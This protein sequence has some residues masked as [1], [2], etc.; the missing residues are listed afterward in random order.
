M[1]RLPTSAVALVAL[2]AALLTGLVWPAPSTASTTPS[3][4]AYAAREL[5]W[6]RRDAEAC[7]RDPALCPA[8]AE[9][10]QIRLEDEAAER[11]EAVGHE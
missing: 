8:C 6:D 9:E 5:E 7:E 4:C 2:A 3:A 10:E 1:C 11:E